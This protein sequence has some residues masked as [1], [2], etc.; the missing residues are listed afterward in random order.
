MRALTHV[1]A[2]QISGR[3]SREVERFAAARRQIARGDL[4]DV[5]TNAHERGQGETAEPKHQLTPETA[6][7]DQALDSVPHIPVTLS[8]IDSAG[9]CLRYPIIRSWTCL[10]VKPT[11]P[12]LDLRLFTLVKSHSAYASAIILVSCV[13]GL[14]TKSCGR[15]LPA[16]DSSGRRQRGGSVAGRARGSRARVKPMRLNPAFGAGEG[17]RTLVSCLG[18]NSSAI[19]LH[20]REGLNFT[21]LAGIA[22]AGRPR[23]GR[24]AVISQSR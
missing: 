13:A 1:G 9:R 17:N 22:S 21:R 20:P 7:A 18:S 5:E 23:G 24:S 4:T 14:M 15:R 10:L 12:S 8:L 2:E 6:E 3:F 19:E 16:V 11:R